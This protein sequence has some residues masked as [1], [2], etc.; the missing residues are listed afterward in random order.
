MTHLQLLPEQNQKL[1][2]FAVVPAIRNISRFFSL[3]SDMSVRAAPNE[4]DKFV[5]RESRTNN[6]RLYLD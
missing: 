6:V 1:L 2:P 4:N 5:N 3:S